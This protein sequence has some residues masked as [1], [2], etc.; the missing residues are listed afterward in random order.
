MAA[1]QIVRLGFVAAF[2]M[3]CVAIGAA[4]QGNPKISPRDKVTIEVAGI[5]P[6]ATF[7]VDSDG[8]ISFP[9]LEKPVKAAGLTVH[10]LETLLSNQLFDENW[11]TV[12]AKVT[13]DLEQIKNK[14]VIVDGAVRSP[15]IVPFAGELTVR[16]ALLLVGSTTPD[17][18]DIARVTRAVPRPAPGAPVPD[19]VVVEV[20]LRDLQ[21]GGKIA[22]DVILEDGDALF[23]AK[24]E[25]VYID[26]YVNRPGPYS[27][28]PGMTL[29]QVITLA[30]G[31]SERGSK[32]RIDILRG[33]TKVK[34]INY[35]KTKVMPGDTITVKARI[36]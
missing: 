11:L 9:P 16:E 2:V 35:D 4:Q 13:A 27:V 5:V 18:G 1:K 24:A 17:A 12:R 6:K 21:T 34:S 7:N 28:Q 22:H 30:G 26:G 31:I 36:F 23:V 3:G 8:M 10:E 25:Q 15:G 29:K 19:P 14:Q 32:G 33:G 20:N